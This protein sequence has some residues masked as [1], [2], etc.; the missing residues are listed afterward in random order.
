[1]IGSECMER[2]TEP[3]PSAI[4]CGAAVRGRIMSIDLMSQA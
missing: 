3:R 4:D 2:R 1:M